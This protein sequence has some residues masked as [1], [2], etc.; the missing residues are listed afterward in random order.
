MLKIITAKYRQYSNV[1]V[2]VS[3]SVTKA[4]TQIISIVLIAKI[5]A[6]DDLGTWSFLSLF[7]TY[8][9]ILNLGIISGLNRELPYTLGMNK[10]EEAT[11]MVQTAYAFILCCSGIACLAGLGYAFLVPMPEK[12]FYGVLA[13]TFMSLLSYYESFLISTFRSNSAFKKLSQAQFIQSILNVISLVLI[14]YYGYY[15]LISKVVIV[16]LIYV[17]VLHYNRPFKV[18]AKWNTKHFVNIVKV[19]FPIYILAFGQSFSASFD[20]LWLLR[21]SDNNMLGYYAFAFYGLTG[22]TILQTAISGYIY[23]KL[24]YAFGQSHD[25]LQQWVYFKK[26]TALMFAILLPI[27]IIGCLLMPFLMEHLF[28]K[29]MPALPAFRILLLAAVFLG[30]NIGINIVMSMKKWKYILQYQS[31]SIVLPLVF[32]VAFPFLITDK[33]IAISS[34]V[35]TAYLLIF[36]A[37][38]IIA[39]R[40]THELKLKPSMQRP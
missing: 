40:A 16:Q 33:L 27:C 8:A 29:Y 6:P 12:L 13:I 23:P 26:I 14:Y 28:P 34:A 19:G 4:L 37:I 20:R 10:Q 36:V 31:L 22:I 7:I 38:C 30:S 21:I 11:E 25:E 15:G 2:Y 9:A 18:A 17:A 1:I 32:I 39:Y 35:L 5:I 24:T 3:S